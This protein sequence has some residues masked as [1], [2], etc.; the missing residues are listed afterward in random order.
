MHVLALTC[1]H[2]GLLYLK[3]L[4]DFCQGDHLYNVKP[5]SESGQIGQFDDIA[6]SPK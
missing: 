3:V 2:K 4:I 6:S 5:C 1:V